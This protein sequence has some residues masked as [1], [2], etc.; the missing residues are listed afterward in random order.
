MAQA[1]T[2]AAHQNARARTAL[3]RPARGRAEH[4]YHTQVSCILAATFTLS[5]AY[6]IGTW[7]AGEPYNTVDPTQP[8]TV[9]VYAVG[10]GL[11][12]LVRLDKTWI[13]GVV[14]AAVAALLAIGMLYYPT[15]YV[16]EAQHTLGWI[17]NDLYLGLLLLA[18]YLCIQRLRRV[19]LTTGE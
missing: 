4:P 6:T 7:I 17:E 15:L 9:L 8:S 12:A 19:S 16:P 3:A 11:A 13:W 10:F 1:D 2:L 14:L 18:A 5:L